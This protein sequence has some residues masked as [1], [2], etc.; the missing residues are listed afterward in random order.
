M[1]AA[2]KTHT[3]IAYEKRFWPVAKFGATINGVELCNAKGLPR[4]F[5]TKEAAIK[6]AL[7]YIAKPPA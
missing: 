7:A 6:A 3:V 1:G 5:A 2:I 4:K